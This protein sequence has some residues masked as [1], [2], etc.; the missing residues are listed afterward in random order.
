MKF[1]PQLE[2]RRLLRRSK[3][4]VGGS[5]PPWWI[6][7]IINALITAAVVYGIAVAVDYYWLHQ[8]GRPAWAVCALLGLLP[9]GLAVNAGIIVMIV[10]GIAA[11]LGKRMAGVLVLAFGALLYSAPDLIFGAGLTP[12]CP[13]LNF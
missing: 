3:P 12:A 8:L 10:G 6:S 13:W 4:S 11:L 1:D 7:W 9:L 2:V 5:A